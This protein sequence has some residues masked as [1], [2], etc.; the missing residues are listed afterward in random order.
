MREL[1]REH[2]DETRLTPGGAELPPLAVIGAGRTGGSIAAAARRA[3][4][5]VELTGREGAL[6]ACRRAEVALLCVPDGAISEACETL[7]PAIPPLRFVG[8]VSGATS[9][10]ALAGARERGA[11]VFSLHPLQTI[12]DPDTDLTGAPCAIAG[13]TPDAEAL[14]ERLTAGL[15]MRPFRVPEEARA[16]YHAAASIASNLLVALEES[17]ASLLEEAGIQDG[18]ELLAPLVLRTAANWAERGPRALTG[19]VARGDM[20]TVERHLAALRETAPELIPLYEALAARARELTTE[21]LET[22]A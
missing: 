19:P 8:H 20:D 2:P 12:P 14:A 10:D 17:A 3:G 4:L 22:P 16:A 21:K 11:E 13:T 18:R 9:L 7:A 1:E 15:S 5:R 6:D